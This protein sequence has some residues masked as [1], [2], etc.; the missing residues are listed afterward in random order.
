MRSVPIVEFCIKSK[1]ISHEANEMKGKKDQDI[2]NIIYSL[3][4]GD[5]S[6]KEWSSDSDEWYSELNAVYT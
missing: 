3:F 6:V 1:I 4:I 5:M 2:R